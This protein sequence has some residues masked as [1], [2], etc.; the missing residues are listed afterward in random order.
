MYVC[1][2]TKNRLFSALPLENLLLS[3]ICCLL[4]NFK[5]LQCG[6]LHPAS[7]TDRVIHAFPNKT[8]GPPGPEIF[9]SG[10]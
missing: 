2:S 7:F 5:H 9:S 8:W 4:C 10:L 3:A 6:L 1:M